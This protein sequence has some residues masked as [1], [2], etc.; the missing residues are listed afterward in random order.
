MPADAKQVNLTGNAGSRWSEGIT[1]TDENDAPLD[2]TGAAFE[3]VIRTSP[4]DTSEPALVSVTAVE[5]PQGYLSVN[6]DTVLVVL[7]PAATALLGRGARPYALW[8]D[9]GDP[10]NAT[11]MVEGTFYSTLVAAA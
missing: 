11:V 6:G 10:V 3:F 5:S 4:V 1:L 9:P 8:L 2:L 7:Y